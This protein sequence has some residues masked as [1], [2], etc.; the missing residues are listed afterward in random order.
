MPVSKLFRCY[1]KDGEVFW[2]QLSIS[3][4]YD[5][6]KKLTHFVGAMD[7]VTARIGI[8]DRLQ[9][10]QKLD[11]IGQLTGGIAH[12]FNNLLAVILGNLEL[13]ED[14]I[15]DFRQKELISNSIEATQHGAELTR[16]MLSF[17]RQAPLQPTAVDLNQLVRN[18]KN[19]I[20]RTLP[21]TIS[22]ETSLLAG[23]WPV[24][25]DASSTES[26]LLNLILNARDAMGDGG[27]LTIETSNVRIDDDYV[28]LRGEEIDPGRYVLLAVSDNGEGIAQ[29]N[30][31]KIFEP[32]FTTKEVGDGSGLGLSM[33][34]GFMKQS[35]GT[36][37]VYSELGVGTTFKLYFAAS[38]DA[39]VPVPSSPAPLE[40]SGAEKN[41]TILLVEDNAQVLDA[42]CTALQKTGYRV[43]TAI[44]GDSAR[45]IFEVEPGID[46]LVTDI[47]MP[48]ELQGTTL[49]KALRNLRPDL[50]V[51]FMSGYAS[52]ATVHG[53][54]LRAQ[55]I[56]LMKP[57][58]REDLLRAVDKALRHAART[59]ESVEKCP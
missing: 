57:V 41:T 53:N 54:G 34:E 24:K 46:L 16:N 35:G 12:D 3:P 15:T 30:L 36:V 33:L 40:K 49:A 32:F 1:R 31:A 19:W 26:G 2:N 25:V 6:D 47:V 10:T 7:D 22:V 27:N 51:V 38:T 58:R 18:M 14:K 45:E 20:E 5:I 42:I 4:V 11:A 28:E 39:A 56:R 8:E 52:E 9:H 23:L 29:E 37:R 50:P 48:G 55:D 21:S 44:S 13:L 17:A 43:L 59:A